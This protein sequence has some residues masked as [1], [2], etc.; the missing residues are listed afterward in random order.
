MEKKER[1]PE[2]RSIKGLREMTDPRSKSGIGGV[3]SHI[4]PPDPEV[5]E[6][7]TR[8]QFSAEY[9]KRIL[10]EVDSC[11]ELGQIGAILRRE[12]LYSSNLGKWRRQRAKGTLDGLTPQKR[13]KKP[14]RVDP[15]DK[16]N[17]ELERENRRLRK[18]LDQAEKIIE[19][20]K[21]VAELLGIPLSSSE[22]DET[23]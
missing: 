1:M 17:A 16:R 15:K 12:G 4:A 2:V 9:K 20:Q 14:K 19:I 11:T 6:K 7:A 10:E 5:P 13:G 22:N 8:R 21:K 23:R 3:Q 18:K